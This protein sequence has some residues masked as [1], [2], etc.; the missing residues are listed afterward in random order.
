MPFVRN[1]P[2]KP[3]AKLP[4]SLRVLYSEELSNVSPNGLKQECTKYSSPN[5]MNVLICFE[6]SAQKQNKSSTWYEQRIGRITG[7]IAHQASSTISTSLIKHICQIL[8]AN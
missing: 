2:L 4:H 3:H 7:S 5:E 1:Q 6:E 8:P